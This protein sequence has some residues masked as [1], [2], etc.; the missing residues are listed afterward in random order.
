MSEKQPRQRTFHDSKIDYLLADLIDNLLRK[1]P[2]EKKKSNT[3]CM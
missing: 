2:F 3:I 1:T